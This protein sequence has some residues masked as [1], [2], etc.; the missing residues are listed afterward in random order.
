[1]KKLVIFFIGIA[2]FL[3]ANSA[4]QFEPR[5]PRGVHQ[6][7]GESEPFNIDSRHVQYIKSKDNNKNLMIYAHGGGGLGRADKTRAEL[8][9]TFGFDVL[10]FDAFAM[11]GVQPLW[12]N[13]NLGDETKQQLVLNVLKGAVK[14][15][16]ARN[17]ETI[18]LYGQSN[19]ARSIL[20]VLNDLE[21]TEQKAIKL[22]LSEAPSNY[23]KSMPEKVKI[24]TYFFVGAMDNWAGKSEADLMWERHNPIAL[25]TNKNWYEKQLEIGSP[26]HLIVYEGAAH[27]IHDGPLQAVERDMGGRGKTIGFR[28]AKGEALAHYESDLKRISKQFFIDQ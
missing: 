21:E 2:L 19:G 24:P 28:G 14:F 15:A 22:I 13:R 27:G 3:N 6:L 10:F 12:G 11:N 1:M 25:I 7:V 16:N 9:G 23:G 4:T 8:F 20:L 5:G 17:Y 18:V 26:V